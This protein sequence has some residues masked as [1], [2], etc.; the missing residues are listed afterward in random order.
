MLG[1]WSI[2]DV[3]PTIAPEL[4][5]DNLEVGDGTQAMRFFAELMNPVLSL[6][7]RASLRESLL[8]YCERDTLAMVKMVHFF[9]NEPDRD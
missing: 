3:L 2:K 7:R 4:A 9:G 5:Y 8:R 1:S 6:A